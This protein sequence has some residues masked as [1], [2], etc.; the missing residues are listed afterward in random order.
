MARVSAGYENGK[1]ARK[2]FYGKTR[3]EVVREAQAFLHA[4]Q[5]GGFAPTGKDQK[6]SEWLMRWLEI[7][8][9]SPP[10]AAKTVKS[11][12]EQVRNHLI[13]DLG[14][15]PLRK[16]TSQHIQVFMKTK[17]DAGLSGTSVNGIH[18]VLRAS[19]SQAI[20][21]RQLVDN[22]AKHVKPPKVSNRAE[23]FFTSEELGRLFA[24]VKGHH[25]EN[26]FKIAPY[27]GLR[28][29]EVTGLRWS[30]VNFEKST[31]SVR[32]QLQ[33]IDGKP[34]LIPPKSQSSKRTLPV[35]PEVLDILRAQ[36]SMI[37]IHGYANE[38]GLVFVSSTGN[39]LDPKLVNKHLKAHCHR[40]GL[41]ALSY[42]CF[43]HT[44]ATLMLGAGE[45]AY[46]VMNYLGHSQISL[47]VNTY[48]GVLREAQKRA[49][50]SLK[51]AIN[52]K[53]ADFQR[54]S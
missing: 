4:F 52:G 30:D 39:P 38:M 23:E 36:Q 43:R 47:T 35:E 45:E 31:I 14:H 8:V 19:L 15:I 48:G 16:L 26:L 54:P 37:M 51:N 24:E 13:P 17:L 28:I 25:L 46:E 20:R 6:L 49:A 44:T 5:S 29:G 34:A 18:R 3:A 27:I 33:W 21:D 22:V 41:R 40:A 50:R 42:H 2:Y 1:P 7:Y 9:T 53:S 12:S 10:L 11:Y 32:N